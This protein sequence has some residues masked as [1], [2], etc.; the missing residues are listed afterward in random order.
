MYE[1][2]NSI[3]TDKNAKGTLFVLK[4]YPV[5]QYGGEKLNLDKVIENKVGRLFQLTSQ[6][7]QVISF[8]E[9]ICLYDLILSQ[10]K[11]V[12]ILE[13][14]QYMNLYPVNV[15]LKSDVISS[16]LVHF[17]DDASGDTELADISEYT[18]I[19]SNFVNTDQGIACC[20]NISDSQLKSEKVER[21]IV[22]NAE[23]RALDEIRR[24]DVSEGYI[25]LCNEI[26][27]YQLVQE[28]ENTDLTYVV[29]WESY[30]SGKE[31]IHAALQYLNGLYSG[32]I[33]TI[34]ISRMNIEPN[35]HYPEVM[36]IMERYWG[37][38]SFRTIKTYD[39][40]ELEKGNKKVVSISQEKIVS[41]L[42]EQVEKCRFG[43]TFKD[44]FVTAPTGAGKSLIFQLPA[45]Y[46]GEKYNLVTLVITPLIGLMNDQVQALES[47]G[48][49]GARTIN[50]DIS[51]IIKQ[52]ILEEVAN[53][54]CH[55]LYLS[56]ESLLSRSDIETLIGK[57]RIGMLVVDEAH[58]VTTWGKQFRPDYWYLG[59]TVFPM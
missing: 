16:L 11:E 8:D 33:L 38:H 59:E 18:Y 14:P 54:K 4:G 55:I 28:L 1:R 22:K 10:Y 41:D 3:I 21:I 50:S 19:Y 46:I 34:A 47:R 39:M 49:H 24:E 17:D 32:R 9:F 26:D 58:I 29:A 43:K 52:E 53:G 42:I 15:E 5:D 40:A 56:P 6:T 23:A 12:V 20:Y 36:D 27:Y 44:I 45:I 2:V 37:Y 35:V 30:I 51:P 25:N 13:N 57:R 31:V 7:K 48:Y